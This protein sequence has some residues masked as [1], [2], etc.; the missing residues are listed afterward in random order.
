M[1]PI[2]RNTLMAA[3]V[4]AT[5]PLQAAEQG[6]LRITEAWTRPMPAVGSTAAGYLRIENHG[7]EDDRLVAVRGDLAARLE[8]H[9]IIDDNGVARMRPLDDGLL[10]PA[11]GEARLAPGGAHLMLYELREPLQPGQRLPLKLEFARAGV[12]AV[13]LHVEAR[14]PESAEKPKEAGPAGG[15]HAH[16]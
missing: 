11:G 5:L 10:I 13:S 7:A 9:Q 12:V 15:E 3:T 16:H 2:L 1:N 14:A 8:L 6:A 4:L